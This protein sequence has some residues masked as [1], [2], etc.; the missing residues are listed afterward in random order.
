MKKQDW[1]Q[2]KNRIM[3][4]AYDYANEDAFDDVDLIVFQ[5]KVNQIKEKK[6]NRSNRYYVED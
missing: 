6:Q 4:K 2:Q 5:S 1:N 3:E